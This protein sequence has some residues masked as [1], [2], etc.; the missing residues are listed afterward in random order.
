MHDGV[1]GSY[2]LFFDWY[3]YE[4][5]MYYYMRGKY[6]SFTHYYTYENKIILI[7]YDEDKTQLLHRGEYRGDCIILDGDE[8][9]PYIY[10][11]GSPL[12]HEELWDLIFG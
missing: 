10:N 11:D 8:N 9:F 7:Y 2:D 4:V 1:G 12:T 3:S 5:R 6:Y